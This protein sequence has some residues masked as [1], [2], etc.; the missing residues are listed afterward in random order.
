MMYCS[1]NG[2]K[3]DVAADVEVC[4]P[5]SRE[6]E[7][8][9]FSRKSCVTAMPMLANEREVRSHARKVRSAVGRCQSRK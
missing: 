7:R 5:P 6:S 3:D 2:D 8:E 1:P 4:L 9:L